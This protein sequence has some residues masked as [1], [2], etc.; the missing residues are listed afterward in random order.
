MRIRSALASVFVLAGLLA[1]TVPAEA[2]ELRERKAHFIV[3]VPDSWKVDTEGNF[4]I[5]FPKDESFHL[6]MQGTSHGLTQEEK[7]E[8]H[9]I[10]F[11]RGHFSDIHVTRHAKHVEW[12]NFKG[13]EVFGTG[14]ESNGAPGK[15]FLLLIVDKKDNSKGAVVV[16]TGTESGFDKHHPG[17]YEAL[18]SMRTY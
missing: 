5:A 2:N 13:V 14:K 9:A 12:N 8:E 7:D 3:D 15:F 18:H 17:I 4:A 1:V 10:S 16:G 6:R 11:L